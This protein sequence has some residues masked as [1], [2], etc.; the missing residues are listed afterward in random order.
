LLSDEDPEH[1]QQQQQ[2]QQQPAGCDGLAEAAMPAPAAAEGDEGRT[3]PPRA[4]RAA[5]Y[6]ST[7]DRF[8]VGSKRGRACMARMP[9]QGCHRSRLL[10]YPI[11]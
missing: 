6:V 3:R 10:H 2:Q 9:L 4:T 7:S 11:L 1:Q 5:Q 8:K